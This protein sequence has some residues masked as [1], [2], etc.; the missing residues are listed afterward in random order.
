[1]VIFIVGGAKSGK[2]KFAIEL[3][4]NYI[5][6]ENIVKNKTQGKVKKSYIAT[7]QALDDE[8]KERIEK[9]KKERSLGWDTFEEPLNI[10]V[11]LKELKEQYSVILID[12]I[13]LW[14]SNLF[15][16]TSQKDIIKQSIDEFVD[17]LNIYR[18]QKSTV[19]FIV[20]NE[21]GMGIVPDNKLARKFRDEAGALNQKISTLANEVYFVL[22]GIPIKIKG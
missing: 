3:A 15:L 6:S 12:C 5:H 16:S 21:V 1:M 11:L 7:A 14:L 18:A 2:S 20:S 22:S 10:S 17:V 4:E 9:H 19:L 13:T 8:M